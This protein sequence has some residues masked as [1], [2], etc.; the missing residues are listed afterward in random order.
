MK[1]ISLIIFPLVLSLLCSCSTNTISENKT[2][3]KTNPMK[4]I[5]TPN[6]INYAEATTE[7]QEQIKKILNISHNVYVEQVNYEQLE[8]IMSK[9][10]CYLYVGDIVNSQNKET[11][12]QMINFSNSQNYPLLYFDINDINLDKLKNKL[13]IQDINEKF[14]YIQNSKVSS[15]Q[16]LA[17]YKNADDVYDNIKQSF[18]K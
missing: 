9:G 18:T 13:N 4:I 1:K 7:N 2:T 8:K 6:T 11:I 15:V 3:E 12:T 10:N 5:E 14:I 16:D 17:Q